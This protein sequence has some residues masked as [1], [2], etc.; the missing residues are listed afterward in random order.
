MSNIQK[1]WQIKGNNN[2]QITLRNI[3]KK[4]FVLLLNKRLSHKVKY[5]GRKSNE[6]SSK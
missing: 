1:K 3:A 2:T 6:I 4:I 5:I